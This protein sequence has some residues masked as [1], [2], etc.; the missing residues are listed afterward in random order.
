[1][2]QW[3]QNSLENTLL[4][5]EAYI[6]FD[7][8]KHSLFNNVFC[9]EKESINFSYCKGTFLAAA[10]W[11][12]A[13]FLKLQTFSGIFWAL[14][15]DWSLYEKAILGSFPYLF[16]YEV[17]TTKVDFCFYKQ[18]SQAATRLICKRVSFVQNTNNG[19][20]SNIGLYIEKITYKN[21]EKL[22]KWNFSCLHLQLHSSWPKL[23][24]QENEI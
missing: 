17:S 14:S 18:C 5:M 1:M 8:L 10:H 9:F 2:F 20:S 7:S 13:P 4:I 23:R 6:S 19:K 11:F 22:W 3:N 15:I 24:F 12:R 21:Y 16:S